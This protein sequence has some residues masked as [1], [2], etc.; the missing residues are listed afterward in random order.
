M[1][2]PGLGAADNRAR[3]VGLILGGMVSQAI[4]AAVE[5]GLPGELAGGPVQ[6]HELA[7]RCGADRR[8]LER[9]LRALVSFDVLDRAPDGAFALTPLGET[10]LGPEADGQSLAG[11]ALFAG[12]GWLGAARAALADSVRTGVSA[13]RCAH[14]VDFYEFMEDH[15]DL[16]A[17]YEGWAGYSCG[18][19]SLAEHVLAGYDFSAARHVV[20]VGGRYG[21]LLAQILSVTPGATGTLFDMPQVE[22]RARAHLRCEGLEDRCHVQPGSFFDAVPKGGDLYIL[23]NVLVDWDDDRAARILRNCRTAMAPHGVLLTIE[24]VLATSALESRGL[25]TYDLWTMVHAGGMRDE[26]ALTRLI[27]EAGFQVRRVIPTASAA[28]TLFEATPV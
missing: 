6:S 2:D 24:A 5:L 16:A 19:D 18:V 10:L 21:T 23:S 14:G 22:D 13:F 12:S 17:L 9:L 26:A 25:S 27:A 20:D 7:A 3:M 15:P 11:M 4:S 1:S 8:Y 28:A